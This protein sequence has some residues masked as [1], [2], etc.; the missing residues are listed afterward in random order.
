MLFRENSARYQEDLMWMGPVAFRYYV[1]A[2]I[3]Y[4]QS[5]CAANDSGMI[6][7]FAG[8]LEFRL[9]HE[10]K[11]LVPIAK[12]SPLHAHMSSNIG[13]GSTFHQRSTPT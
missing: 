6:D 11:Q 8:L 12:R 4:I 9:Q 3:R 2:A 1:E 7:C 13:T 5:D 10:A